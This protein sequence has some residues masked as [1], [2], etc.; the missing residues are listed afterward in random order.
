[1]QKQK[2][3]YIQKNY[4]KMRTLFLYPLKPD[5]NHPSKTTTINPQFTKVSAPSSIIT[6]RRNTLFTLPFPLPRTFLP[7]SSLP[8][9]TLPYPTLPVIHTLLINPTLPYPALTDILFILF[10][11]IICCLLSTVIYYLYYLLFILFTI[12]QYLLLFL[13]I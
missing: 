7:F 4:Y 13:S 9:R 1:M 6:T 10:I 8:Y 5:T 3:C 2:S 11:I 12:Y